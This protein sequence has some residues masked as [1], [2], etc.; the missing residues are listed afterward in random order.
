MD[1]KK[2]KIPPIPTKNVCFEHGKLKFDVM[3]SCAYCQSFNGFVGG[4]FVP[5]NIR[6]K[7]G[8]PVWIKLDG[9]ELVVETLI[10]YLVDKNGYFVG[11]KIVELERFDIIP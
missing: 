3:K 10:N 6:T 7:T 4:N 9:G 8:A 11:G 1:N 2:I 5:A